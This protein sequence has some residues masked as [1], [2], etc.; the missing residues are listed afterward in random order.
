MQ[1]IQFKNEYKIQI[2]ESKEANLE[3][4]IYTLE[5]YSILEWL[6]LIDKISKNDILSMYHQIFNVDMTYEIRN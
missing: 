4:N 1:D 5:T 3:I 6:Y 2:E